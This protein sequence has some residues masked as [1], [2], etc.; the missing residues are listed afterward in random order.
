MVVK[1]TMRMLITG[2]TG[3]LGPAI[4]YE[5]SKKYDIIGLYNKNALKSQ[6]CTFKRVD[7]TKKYELKDALTN[8]NPDIIIHAAALTNVDLCEENATLAELINVGA[9]D[10]ITEYCIKLNIPLVYISTDYV[11][12]GK[13]GNYS[14]T[15]K[16][17]PINH[18]GLTKYKGEQKVQKHKR[19]LI[20]R[21]SIY[22]WNI[23]NKKC[24][25]ER[26]IESLKSCKPVYGTDQINSMIFTNYL[27]K[28]IELLL[29]AN[30]TGIYNVVSYESK[31]KYNFAIKIS[32]IF[33]FSKGCIKH[34]DNTLTTLA[35]RP[36]KT[37]LSVRKVEDTLNIK[38]PDCATSLEYMKNIEKE[39]KTKFVIC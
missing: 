8:I 15:S 23:T 34:A 25:A 29:S 24:F 28:I 27:A 38:L 13:T 3:L 39:F 11:F 10:I 2:A 26:V 19:S 22:G 31:S 9:T 14:E 6:L 32:E 30:K 1:I 36:Q 37:D 21:T 35:K 4:I 18:Y 12:D 16:P 17:N 7:L 5:L 20:L 33:G